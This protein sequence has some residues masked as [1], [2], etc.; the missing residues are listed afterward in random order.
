MQYVL[1]LN[2]MKTTFSLVDSTLVCS[3]VLDE[4]TGN[5]LVVRRKDKLGALVG[6]S[7]VSLFLDPSLKAFLFCIVVGLFN[8]RK[9]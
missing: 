9:Q 4:A 2:I 6:L 7:S 5:T 1:K 3:P 8:Q